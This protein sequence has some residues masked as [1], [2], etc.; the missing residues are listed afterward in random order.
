MLRRRR[1]AVAVTDRTLALA[2]RFEGLVVEGPGEICVA[3]TTTEELRDVVASARADHVATTVLGSSS[4]MPGPIDTDLVITTACLRGIVD[5]QPDD[6]TVVVRAGT[7][8][9]ELAGALA[10][11]RQTAVLPEWAPDRSVGGIVATGASGYRR[12]RYGPTR[13]RVLGVTVV[14]GYGEIVRG[15]GQLVKN[16]TGYDLPRLFTG[17]HGELGVITEVSWK[18]WPV[19]RASRTVTIDDPSEVLRTVH[20]PLAV[21]ETETSSSCFVEGSDAGVADACA[22]LGA[23]GEPGLDW[24]VPPATPVVVSVRV[25]PRSVVAAVDVVREHAPVS[26]VAQHGVGLIDVGFDMITGERVEEL[27]SDVGALG[28]IAVVQPHVAAELGM[29][30]WGHL[31]DGLA[32][33]RRLKALFDP[34]GI[35]NRGHLPGGL[36]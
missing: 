5:H 2:H 30:P 9:G 15:G 3:P 13:D 14:T 21:L 1:G 18:L 10:E 33:Q 6:L 12:L 7:T 36:S 19:P 31:P 34:A 22:T 25:P 20:R 29:D 28:G 26:F 4:T 27:R 35:L 23:E 11:H 17:S 32:I 24:P 8:L 16:V